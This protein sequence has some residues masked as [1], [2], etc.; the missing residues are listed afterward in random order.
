MNSSVNTHYTRATPLTELRDDSGT[1]SY[2]FSVELPPGNYT[3]VL[4]GFATTN[5]TKNVVNLVFFK[6]PEFTLHGGVDHTY[7]PLSNGY[8]PIECIYTNISLQKNKQRFDCYFMDPEFMD[9]IFSLNLTNHVTVHS[10][11][12]YWDFYKV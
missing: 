9:R 11:V 5:Y 10:F 4:K 8:T 3:P 6:I 1:P 7:L 12:L 2:S